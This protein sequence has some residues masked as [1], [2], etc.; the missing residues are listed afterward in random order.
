MP[1]PSA[2]GPGAEPGGSGSAARGRGRT[3]LCE[4]APGQAAHIQYLLVVNALKIGKEKQLVFIPC[5]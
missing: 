4:H 3:D 2:T 1:V 5:T